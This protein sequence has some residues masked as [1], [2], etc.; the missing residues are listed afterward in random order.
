MVCFWICL[1][2]L[3][4]RA[5]EKFFAEAAKTPQFR[6]FHGGSCCGRPEERLK[7]DAVCGHLNLGAAPEEN[8]FNNLCRCNFKEVEETLE[9]KRKLGK[10]ETTLFT[11]HSF[12]HCCC[13]YWITEQLACL[14]CAFPSLTQV[15]LPFSHFSRFFPKKCRPFVFLEKFLPLHIGFVTPPPELVA[16]WLKAQLLTLLFFFPALSKIYS[17]NNA[18]HV[19]NSQVTLA[20]FWPIA[21]LSC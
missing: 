7:E 13:V 19:A 1:A 17:R 14:S 12:S 18:F 20:V 3:M 9:G 5:G 2:P 16:S 6:Q 10:R 21:F 8:N 11:L 4:E 15:T